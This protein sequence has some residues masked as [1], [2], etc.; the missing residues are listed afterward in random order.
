MMSVPL[1]DAALMGAGL[2]LLLVVLGF[3]LLARLILRRT[4]T[5]VS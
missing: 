1:Y 3:N 2:F 4:T 5:G